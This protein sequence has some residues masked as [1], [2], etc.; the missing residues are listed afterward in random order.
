MLIN[1]HYHLNIQN[2]LYLLNIYVLRKNMAVIEILYTYI[3][4]C[5]YHGATLIETMVL[6]II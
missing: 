1:K 3:L 6:Y 2:C 5:S 4:N